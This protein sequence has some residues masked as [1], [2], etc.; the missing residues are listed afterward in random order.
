[1]RRISAYGLCLDDEGRVL[2]TRTGD[3]RWAVPGGVVGHGEDPRV[4]VQRAF[5]EQTGANAQLDGP[6]DVVTEIIADAAG[7]TVQQDEQIVFDA[8]AH[9][10]DSAIAEHAR[11]ASPKDLDTL[12]LT[13]RG[14]KLLGR[15][16]PAD[17]SVD[18][19]EPSAPHADRRQ[20]FAAYALAT[21]P[22]G[23]VLLALISPGY[24]G[25]GQWHL[26][27][28]GTDLGETAVAGLLRELTEETGQVGRVESVLDVVSRYDGAAMGPEGRPIDMH[29]V[30]A[31]YRVRVDKP[32]KARVTD[33][34]GS[35]EKADWFAPAEALA[36]PLTNT[37]RAALLRAL[38]AR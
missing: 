7:A 3:G 5:A 10:D 14:A 28:G 29:G 24:P 27:G 21:D 35:T 1:V 37:A 19:W 2:L 11:W 30:G 31:I 25:A 22:K 32:T 9:A 12:P 20:R 33:V 23:N 26:P 4:V 15:V 38:A 13:G 18:G 6:R 17:A 8:R 34:G 16:E 36:L